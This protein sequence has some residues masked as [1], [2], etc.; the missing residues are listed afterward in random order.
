MPTKKDATLLFCTYTNRLGESEQV[1]YSALHYE[2]TLQLPFQWKL[3]RCTHRSVSAGRV[4]SAS[5]KSA[6]LD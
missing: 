1:C 2:E 5:A 6:G 4:R 3:D